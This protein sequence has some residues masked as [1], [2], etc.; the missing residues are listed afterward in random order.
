MFDSKSNAEPDAKSNTNSDA[1]SDAARDTRYD[2]LQVTFMRCDE[3]GKKTRK[4]FEKM[5]VCVVEDRRNPFSTLLLLS[6]NKGHTTTTPLAGVHAWPIR[7]PTT[8]PRDVQPSFAEHSVCLRGPS[9]STCCLVALPTAEQRRGFMDRLRAAG[10]VM[11]DLVDRFAILPEKDQPAEGIK[12]GRSTT[13]RSS[14]DADI[15][16]MKVAAKDEAKRQLQ[17]EVDFLLNLHHDGIIAGY[18]IYAVKAGGTE[19]LGMLLDYKKGGDLSSWIPPTGLPEWTVRGITAQLGDALVYLHGIP[20]VHRDL[21]PSNVLCERT[22]DGSVKIVLADFGLASFVNDI[23]NMSRRCGTC[24][25]IAPE[26]FSRTWTKA[27]REESVT[28]ITKIDAFSFGMLL[29]KA[30]FGQNPFMDR[31][32]LATSR[33]NARALLP[34]ADMAGRS[35]EL[36]HLLLGLCA[37]DR[38]QRFSSSQALAA[39]WFATDRSTVPCS[40]GE[41]KHPNVAWAAFEVAA[42]LSCRGL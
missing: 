18:G 1:K 35:D 42:R 6:D 14:A 33:R 15:L 38:H 20:V 17:D 27:C 21:K 9:S 41:R 39:P 40:S 24:G 26:M 16:A 19:A 37:K 3:N 4:P 10:C 28:N 30:V 31:T 34:L 25:F 12:L 7:A 11:Y 5:H 36:Q 23:E 13:P 2:E 8:N 29:Y 22:E 32:E